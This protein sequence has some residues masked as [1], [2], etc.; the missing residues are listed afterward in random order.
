MVIMHN[1]NHSLEQI[2]H[3][4]DKVPSS[5]DLHVI[6]VMWTQGIAYQYSKIL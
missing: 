3:G 6:F 5:Y 2:M 4:M 1:L